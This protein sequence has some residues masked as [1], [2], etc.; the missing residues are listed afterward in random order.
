M[1]NKEWLHNTLDEK[2]NLKLFLGQTVK[3]ISRNMESSR[4]I[5]RKGVIEFIHKD[6][7]VVRHG[8]YNVS[9]TYVDVITSMANEIRGNTVQEKK[10]YARFN[11]EYKRIDKSMLP[12][13]IQTDEF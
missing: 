1:K 7:F 2:M 8:K 3:I 6:Y 9:Y 5:E 10:F 13:E 4:A 11:K 12:V